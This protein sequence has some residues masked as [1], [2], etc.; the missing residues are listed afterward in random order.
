[1]KEKVTPPNN[2]V[3]QEKRILATN[4]RNRFESFTPKLTQAELAEKTII[5]TATISRAM[6][7]TDSTMPHR[8]VVEK[9]CAALGISNVDAM[10]EE[11][12]IT[13]EAV[14]LRE[15]YEFVKLPD[16]S[17]IKTDAAANT[18]R[19][20]SNSE[21]LVSFCKK[22]VP[23]KDNIFVSKEILKNKKLRQYRCLYILLAS[24]EVLEVV[25][26][27][28]SVEFIASSYTLFQFYEKI[29]GLLFPDDRTT[30]EKIIESDTRIICYNDGG[31][32]DKLDSRI[33]RVFNRVPYN[34]DC[35]NLAYKIETYKSYLREI[36]VSETE[37]SQCELHEVKEEKNT[38]FI[39][40]LEK[41]PYEK[42]TVENFTEEN[43]KVKIQR[44]KEVLNV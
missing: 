32:P 26:G 9:I 17:E 36:K 19:F 12:N 18:I 43:N 21:E 5:D 28:K 30:V 35:E 7:L 27:D 41:Y 16:W 38:K 33:F 3:S 6:S 39:S 42:E 8:S 1:M 2:Y 22:L 13:L 24:F 34:L 44:L 29:K 23:N 31:K 40:S 10:Y 25:L 15:F 11:Q 20:N 37:I 14:L 4:L